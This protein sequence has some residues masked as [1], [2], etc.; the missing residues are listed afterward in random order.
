MRNRY[1]T[2][3]ENRVVFV[4]TDE[5]IKNFTNDRAEFIG[6]NGS[7]RNP[8][9]MSKVKLSNRS[10]AALDPCTAMQ[11]V[12]DLGEDEEHEVIFRVGAVREYDDI[13]E[14]IRNFKGSE[15]ARNALD[16]VKRY[17]QQTLGVLKVQ[18][19]DAALNIISNGWLNYQSLACRIWA[20][21]GFYQSGGAFGFRDQLQDTLSLL[22]SK[23]AIVHQQILLNASRQFKEG[24]VQH[25]W[26]P[27]TGRGVRTTC[28]DDY[29]WLPFVTVRY[30]SYTGDKGILDAP[31]N[32]LEGRIL[33]AG[34]ESYYDLPIRSHETTTL[35]D[36]CVRSIEHGLRFGEHGIPLIGSGDW[37]DGMD[38]VGEHGKGESVWLAFF[39][40]DILVRFAVIAE[41]KNDNAFAEKCRQE[42]KKLKANIEKNCWDGQWY[43]RAYFDDGTPLGSS[44]NEECQID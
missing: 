31:A 16:K 23:P 21:S 29:L 1:N 30:I 28:S 13:P 20:R 26:H 43:R 4:D 5:P 19:P 40:Y 17:W 42:A 10:G 25:W 34:E 11:V 14:M 2:E 12:F 38:K 22:Y 24:D 35:Y 32:F 37:N 9:A 15:Y 44:T 27:P 7:I 8:E 3:F 33:N 39:L 6:R 36:H 18:T 41:I